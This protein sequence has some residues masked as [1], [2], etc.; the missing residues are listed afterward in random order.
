MDNLQR[1]KEDLERLIAEGELL[2][3]TILLENDVLGNET[4]R[5]LKEKKLPSFTSRYDIWYSETLELVKQLLPERLDD[6]IKLYKNEKRKETDYSTYTISDY[7]I[8]LQVTFGTTVRADGKA[9]IPKFEQQKNIL[10]AIK[11]RFESSLFDIRQILQADIFD[12]E[13]DTANELLKNGFIRAAGAIAGVVL[14]KHLKETCLN[15]KLRV[16]KKNPCVSDFNDLLKENNVIELPTW[17]YIQHL[18]DIRNMCDHSKDREPTKEEAD[19]LIQGVKK[20][21]KT[22]Y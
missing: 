9:A 13:L 2:Y 10:G 1:F 12:D 15:H 5:V 22:V 3:Y 14:E 8:G 16:T 18:A 20:I 17:R 11:K 21:S 7:L 4:K 6:F 19:G